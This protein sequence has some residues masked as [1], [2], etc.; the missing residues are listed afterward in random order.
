VTD[1]HESG[2]ETFHV[3]EGTGRVWVG[4]PDVI[5]RGAGSVAG[6]VFGEPWEVVRCAPGTWRAFRG[7]SHFM[8]HLEGLEWLEVRRWHRSGWVASS[9]GFAGAFTREDDLWAV[10]LR[11][12]GE[13]RY[14]LDDPDCGT[15][16]GV[17]ARVARLA[18]LRVEVLISGEGRFEG[19]RVAL[20]PE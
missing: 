5:G 11:R 7:E 6:V 14:V 10:D 9:S 18:A 1:L 17:A 16:I 13:G 20:R 8:A 3:A 15:R 2:Y 4:D 12:T 19:V